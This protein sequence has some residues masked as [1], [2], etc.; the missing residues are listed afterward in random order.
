MNAGIDC[1]TNFELSIGCKLTA[2]P[3]NSNQTTDDVNSFPYPV[4]TNIICDPTEKLSGHEE[5]KFF[6]CTL[7]AYQYSN[8]VD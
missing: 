7:Q 8:C 5:R 1:H 3:A 6:A 4:L 2:D